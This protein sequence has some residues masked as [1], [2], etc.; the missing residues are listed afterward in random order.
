LCEGEEFG[1]WFGRY[2]SDEYK[3]G[4]LAHDVNAAIGHLKAKGVAK[5]AVIGFCWVSAYLLD[6]MR[7]V[8][9]LCLLNFYAL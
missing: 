5:V 6:Y 1:T 4:R 7:R 8:I 3:T 2:V 9:Y